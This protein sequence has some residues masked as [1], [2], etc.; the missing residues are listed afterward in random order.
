MITCQINILRYEQ[1]IYKNNSLVHRLTEG[2]V[3]SNKGLK[4]ETYGG[5]WDQRS[6]L[7]RHVSAGATHVSERTERGARRGV[8]SMKRDQVAG[9][10]KCE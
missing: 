1:D 2:F 8:G 9:G 5:A 4:Q 3:A 7:N 6:R 10:K